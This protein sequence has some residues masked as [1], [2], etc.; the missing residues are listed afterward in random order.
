MYF[1]SD[2]HREHRVRDLPDGPR[3]VPSAERIVRGRGGLACD[4]RKPQHRSPD[5][6]HLRR[7]KQSRQQA[8]VA[9][10]LPFR[11]VPELLFRQRFERVE[12]RGIL[13]ERYVAR[14]RGTTHLSRPHDDDDSTLDDAW[15]EHDGGA[16]TDAD[17][18]HGYDRAESQ[19]HRSVSG[20]VLHPD[21][22]APQPPL[23]QS[24][25]RDSCR[26]SQHRSRVCLHIPPHR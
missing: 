8:L 19:V 6:E 23:H 17:V 13:R 10:L 9:R 1:I 20:R 22:S 5:V 18:R 7:R 15:S 25:L 4:R 21:V 14:Y 11:R 3:V 2:I 24:V 12:R 26:R 16:G